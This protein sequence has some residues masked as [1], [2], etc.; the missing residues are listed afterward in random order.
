M[1]V[2]IVKILVDCWPESLQQRNEGG[3]LPIHCLCRVPDVNG[4]GLT[5]SGVLHLLVKMYPESV[6]E[7][8]GVGYLPI[9]IA[10]RWRSP[11]FCKV[12]IDAYPESLRVGV[13]VEG[14]FP[15]H[16]ACL[17]T[18]ID[19]AK[20]LLDLYPERTNVRSSHGTLPI[21]HASTI[22]SEEKVEMIKWLLTEDPDCASKVGPSGELPIHRACMF[23]KSVLKAVQLLFDAHPEGI[24]AHDGDGETPLDMARSG[25]MSDIVDVVSFLET[26]LVYAQQAQ[27]SAIMSGNN[28]MLPLHTALKEK[29][30]LG[31]IKLL[32]KGNPAALQMTDSRGVLPIHIACSCS[33]VGVV[34]FLAELFDG[35]LN[36]GDAN[37]DF[38]LH[39]ACRGGNCGVVRYLLEE[40]TA[41]VS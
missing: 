38:A 10:A 23:N 6:R 5:A 1:S 37:G 4:A 21:H 16:S 13:E 36:S 35:C 32:V 31:A 33:T 34:K 25:G 11:E 17:E 14:L 3:R 12:L 41:G 9:H 15:I 20:Y 2:E 39:F 27:D 8:N 26:Q 28:G 40:Q 19:T 24:F 22:E 7:V 18:R 30:S 29:A